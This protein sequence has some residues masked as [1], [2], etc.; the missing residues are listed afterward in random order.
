MKIPVIKISF[1]ELQHKQFAI[2]F[3]NTLNRINY[4]QGHELH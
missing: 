3:A 1:S 4:T 2:E